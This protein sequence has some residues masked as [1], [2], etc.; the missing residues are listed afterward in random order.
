[1]INSQRQSPLKLGSVILED[2]EKGLLKALKMSFE[3][4]NKNIV[5]EILSLVGRIISNSSHKK[6]VALF[7]NYIFYFYNAYIYSR[8][9]PELQKEIVTDLT[10]I[11]VSLINYNIGYKFNN[12]N[13]PEQKESISQFLYWAYFSFVSFLHSL[14]DDANETHLATVFSKVSRIPNHFHNHEK[15]RKIEAAILEAQRTNKSQ[16]DVLERQIEFEYAPFTLHRHTMLALQMWLWYLYDIQIYALEKTLL[17]SKY[18]KIPISKIEDLINDLVFLRQNESE[19]YLGLEGWDFIDR[20]GMEIYSPPDTSGWI[21]K[22]MIILFLQKGYTSNLNI[23]KIK[24]DRQFYFIYND[25]K[26]LFKDPEILLE[27]WGKIIKC[28]TIVE[29]TRRT[30]WVSNTFKQLSRRYD[31]FEEQKI[32]EQPISMQYVE[33]FKKNVAEN[34]HSTV[35]CVPLFNYF[36][37]LIKV[38]KDKDLDTLGGWIN[39]KAKMNFIERFHQEAHFIENLGAK[40]ANNNDESFFK[41]VIEK[42]ECTTYNTLLNAI[43][44]MIAQIKEKGYAPSLIIAPPILTYD[45]SISDSDKFIPRWKMNENPMDIQIA[46]LF[47]KIPIIPLYS[48]EN[49]D[50]IIV[51]DFKESFEFR[52]YE[53]DKL[54][55]NMLHVE[56][57]PIDYKE[58]IEIFNS[59]TEDWL[60]A[61][62]PTV[63]TEEEAIIIIMN[64]IRIG[65]WLK[66][67]FIIKNSDAY[68]VGKIGKV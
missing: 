29:L 40:I 22:G 1:M 54:E 35:I 61:I 28:S 21:T 18:I 12:N 7:S 26:E 2:H 43:E 49:E 42:S 56:V 44:S 50:C 11:Y 8:N 33:P 62:S 16:V 68:K 59:H 27:K 55:Y 57:N 66:G 19:G 45:D 24:N 64:H 31:S 30:Q 34:W 41:K 15:I 51:C 23:E 25:V 10:S 5:L 63:I 38:E 65:A 17:L 32:A 3:V 39:I 6:D 4:N 67:K 9:N 60:N 36:G 46:G 14:L 37:N 47:D 48:E 13:S 20:S 52:L 53:T 58:A